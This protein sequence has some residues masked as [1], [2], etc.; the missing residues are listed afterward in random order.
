MNE[1][2]YNDYELVYLIK[3]ESEEAMDLMMRKYDPLIKSVVSY[4]FKKFNNF[5]IDFDDMLQEARI[6]LFIYLK[7]Y[8]RD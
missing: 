5:K 1:K 8:D 4:Y 3:E 2:F 6:A 7:R